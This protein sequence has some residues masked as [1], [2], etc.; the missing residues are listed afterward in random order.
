MP[1][2]RFD[3]V[4]TYRLG[5]QQGLFDALFR[6]SYLAPKEGEATYKQQRTTLLKAEQ[7]CLRAATIST[8][9]DSS[10]LDQIRTASTMDSLVLDIKRCFDNNCEKLKFVDDLLYFEERL[11]ILE[12]PARL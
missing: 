6:Q 1:L 2:S 9:V 11:Y 8:P 12:G 3:F 10:F 7:L 5:K 4:I